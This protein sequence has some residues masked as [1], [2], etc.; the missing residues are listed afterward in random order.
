MVVNQI[1]VVIAQRR[2]RQAVHGTV[3]YEHDPRAAGDEAHGALQECAR[4]SGECRLELL[5]VLL[6]GES[7]K[8]PRPPM[9]R[10][11][12]GGKSASRCESPADDPDVRAVVQYAV[13]EDVRSRGNDF[14][15]VIEL[16]RLAA[17]D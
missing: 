13:F 3:R 16:Q 12:A 8:I 11:V 2:E 1:L 5:V 15:D 17:G 9:D 6:F 7:L 10:L 14:L 4:G